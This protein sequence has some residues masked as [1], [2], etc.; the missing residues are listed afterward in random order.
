MVGEVIWE[1]LVQWAHALCVILVTRAIS[2]LHPLGTCTTFLYQF[3]DLSEPLAPHDIRAYQRLLE[4]LA[5]V[6]HFDHLR[7]GKLLLASSYSV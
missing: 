6:G 2:E 1:D 5:L 4:V 3:P 7:L